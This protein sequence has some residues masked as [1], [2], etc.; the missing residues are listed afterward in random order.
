[1]TAEPVSTATN[2]HEQ[3]DRLMLENDMAQ[4]NLEDMM[5]G[6]ITSSENFR[7][8]TGVSQEDLFSMVTGGGGGAPLVGGMARRLGGFTKK[9][10]QEPK[11]EYEHPKPMNDKERKVWSKY[12]GQGSLARSRMSKNEVTILDSLIK[13]K[14]KRL[15]D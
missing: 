11:K 8:H 9:Y 12:I 4:T 15:E 13:D 10:K 6:S 14:L 2:A 5:Y 7:P 3:M 1:M